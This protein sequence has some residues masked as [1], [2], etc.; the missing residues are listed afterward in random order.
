MS[1]TLPLASPRAEKII[2]GV[3]APLTLPLAALS[4]LKTTQNAGVVVRKA[5]ISNLLAPWLRSALQ[6]ALSVPD[7]SPGKCEC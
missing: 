2:R 3:M 7:T 6:P 1:P 4:E 5:R